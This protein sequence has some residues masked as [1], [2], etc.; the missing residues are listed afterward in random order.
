MVK[1]SPLS[2]MVKPI[3]L[4]V[5]VVCSF[6]IIDWVF[7]DSLSELPLIFIVLSAA[8]ISFLYGLSNLN[9]TP[10]VSEKSK[11]KPFLKLFKFKTFLSFQD[12]L[13]ET[14]EDI[15]THLKNLPP[16]SISLFAHISIQEHRYSISFSH[17]LTAVKKQSFPIS[18][19]PILSIPQEKVSYFQ[20]DLSLPLLENKQTVSLENL[21]IKAN[22]QDKSFIDMAILLATLSK[23]IK[24]TKGPS[25]TPFLCKVPISLFKNPQ[26]LE[27]LKDLITHF[28][29]PKHLFIFLMPSSSIPKYSDF[30]AHLNHQSIQ[31][32]LEVNELPNEPL[33]AFA[34]L[35]YIS[36]ENLKNALGGQIEWQNIRPFTEQPYKIILG[37]LMD[38]QTLQDFLPARVDYACGQAFGDVQLLEDFL[39][40]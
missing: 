36:L 34:G 15:L 30:L 20:Y 39:K 9:I 24:E 33:A 13:D 26:H 18:V 7:P 32:A 40:H 35:V 12:V 1:K 21:E 37:D 23:I 17:L 14:L 31:I 4:A 2:G 27:F 16:S 3:P 38:T 22:S 28:T 8:A 25:H 10:E 6:A 5:L 29:F 11:K 19:R